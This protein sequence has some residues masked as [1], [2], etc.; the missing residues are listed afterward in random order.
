VKIVAIHNG[1][2]PLSENNR[3]IIEAIRAIEDSLF[4]LK[5]TEY[6]GH[7]RDLAFQAANSGCTVLIA[8]GG[9]GTIHEAV[10]GLKQSGKDI[11]LLLL[12]NGTANDL[13]RG[14]ELNWTTEMVVNAIRKLH[15][16][17]IDLIRISQ[18]DSIH[19][20]VNIAD[21]GF[22]GNVVQLL[23]RQRRFI[24]GGIS[25]VIS[26]ARSFFTFKKPQ[27]II[28][29]AE[30]NYVGPILLVAACNGPMF[31]DG[32]YI[33]PDAL[34]DD[35]WMHVTLL[36]KV[37]FLDYVK[38]LARLKRKE[39]IKHPEACYFRTKKVE[40]QIT[41]GK[42]YTEAD[43]E[44]IGEGKIVFEIQEAALKLIVPLN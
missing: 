20:C 21:T 38:N 24:G 16:K 35:G 28:S 8:I 40:V 1:V 42:A 32:L 2:R 12:P 9:D 43:G 11:P 13:T 41:N 7:A 4:F 26:I 25:Y 5:V 3:A 14:L 39:K 29:S 18:S 22:G 27:V 15:S 6:S 44:L 30:K 23:H 17:E 37:N 19:W 34:P 33:A 31:G 10:N 36:G